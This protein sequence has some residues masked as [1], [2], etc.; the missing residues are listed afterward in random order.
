PNQNTYIV[1]YLEELI[2][3]YENN[4]QYFKKQAE[5]LG[6]LERRRKT[7]DWTVDTLELAFDIS[8]FFPA[9]I[10]Q[11]SNLLHDLKHPEDDSESCPINIKKDG[12][13]DFYYVGEEPESI[14]S[15]L[16]KHTFNFEE[17]EFLNQLPTES[18][19]DAHGDSGLTPTEKRNGYRSEL[20]AK[21]YTVK[22]DIFKLTKKL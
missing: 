7:D 5:I 18:W 19:H 16:F 17:K 3:Y 10:V 13:K 4:A 15:L 22:K 11:Y 21:F 8:W 9:E 6:E 14:E 12:F 1:R 2:N 20:L